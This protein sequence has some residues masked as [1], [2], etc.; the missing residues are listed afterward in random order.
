MPE[1]LTSQAKLDQVST[2]RTGQNKESPNVQSK[3]GRLT[4]NSSVT[5]ERT[6]GSRSVIDYQAKIENRAKGQEKLQSAV[7]ETS[8]KIAELKEAHMPIGKIVKWALTVAAVV[9]GVVAL[10]AGIFAAPLV[11]CIVV[12]ILVG[13]LVGAAA[14]FA[15][16]KNNCNLQARAEILEQVQNL[17][18]SLQEANEATID[19]FGEV[20]SVTKEL[21]EGQATIAQQGETIA[22]QKMLMEEQTA[23]IGSLKQ[24][25]TELEQNLTAAQQAKADA[26]QQV[27]DI[28]TKTA[29]LQSALGDVQNQ[30]KENEAEIGRLQHTNAEQAAELQK[31]TDTMKAFVTQQQEMVSQLETTVHANQK[32]LDGML[33]KV[34]AGGDD[35]QEQIE[36][37]KAYVQENFES[38]QRDLTEATV[39]LSSCRVMGDFLE[40]Q[41]AVNVVVLQ[42]TTRLGTMQAHI[43]DSLTKLQTEMR[44]RQAEM[45]AAIDILQQ[46]H[47]E[48]RNNIH[49]L[50]T[51]YDE[52][53]QKLEQCQK[54]ATEALAKAEQEKKNAWRLWGKGGAQKAENAARE[55]NQ[56]AADLRSE[57]DKIA[58]GLD[59]AQRNEGKIKATL[60]EMQGKQEQIQKNCEALGQQNQEFQRSNDELFDHAQK[61]GQDLGIIGENVDKAAAA[62]RN[63]VRNVGNVTS[64]WTGLGALLGAGVGGSGAAVLSF[65]VIAT[66][67]TAVAGAAIGGGLVLGGTWA[68][69]LAAGYT[70]GVTKEY[71]A[72]AKSKVQGLASG[73]GSTVSSSMSAIGHI[74]SG[75]KSVLGSISSMFSIDIVGDDFNPF[76]DGKF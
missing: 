16:H 33:A 36:A 11:C 39:K 38:V 46:N 21:D 32:C 44:E 23:E 65:G 66:G 29:E 15:L 41:R 63:V 31:Q 37:I 54:G 10:A 67:A 5:A 62:A 68:L 19:A 52:T 20:D 12:G 76:A 64:R 75:I 24:Q 2:T 55:L 59:E 18:G 50:Q 58:T 34:Q 47:T 17:Q 57:L 14:G 27:M 1:V 13:V 28:Q 22:Q 56:K 45:K 48:A 53:K 43:I 25:N 71:I 49:Q 70:E 51:A 72:S 26:E 61:I 42:S 30:I 40:A 73:I 4:S 8:T 3:K 9:G 35:V 69:A 60:G 74:G 7:A 6:L